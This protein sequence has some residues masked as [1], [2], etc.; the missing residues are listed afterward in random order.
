MCRA[1]AKT[2]WSVR[3]RCR[4]SGARARSGYPEFD[5][6]WKAVVDADILVTMHSSDS[7]Y[8]RYQSDW[9]GPSEMLPFRLDAFRL[10]TGGQAADRGHDGRLRAAM[11][12]SPGSPI[13]GSRPSRTAGTGSARSSNTWRHLQE[14]AAGLRRRP[15][16]AV[17]AQ[18]LRQPVPRGRHRRASS[19]HRGRPPPLRVGL[20]APRGPGRAVQ[21]RRPPSGGPS[22]EDVRK[23]MGG[24]LARSC[25]S[26][27]RRL[28]LRR[29]RP[30]F[31]TAL[32]SRSRPLVTAVVMCRPDADLMSLS[33]PARTTA[34]EE[35]TRDA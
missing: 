5:P 1:G 31:T 3:R 4:A 30:P 14:D 15:G 28:P 11:A 23:I 18:R 8:S 22:D 13:S 27:S 2:S 9:T 17:Q 6:F 25:G 32:T 26:T 7:G 35:G 16:R 19:T 34:P 20:S 33:M 12:S 29:S 21:L 24:N 10:M